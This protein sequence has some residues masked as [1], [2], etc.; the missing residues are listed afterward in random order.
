[1]RSKIMLRAA[2]LRLIDRKVEGTHYHLNINNRFL[3]GGIAMD[4]AA[5][6]VRVADALAEEIAQAVERLELA[7]FPVTIPGEV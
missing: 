7:G 3:R 2:I 4:A 5:E 6:S 1:M